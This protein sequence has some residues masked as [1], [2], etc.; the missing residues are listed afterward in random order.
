[1]H[2]YSN[3][4]DIFGRVINCLWQQT[5]GGTTTALA[6]L[7]YGYDFASNRQWRRDNVAESLSKYFDEYYGYDGVYRLTGLA[8]GQLTGTPPTGVTGQTFGEDWTL[9]PTGN[10]NEYQQLSDASTVTLDQTR[11]ASAVNEITAIDV[12]TP[13]DAPWAQPGYDAAGNMTT[14][15]QPNS[16]GNPYAATFD[17]WQRMRFLYD[18]TVPTAPVQV[19]ENQYDGRNFRVRRI[20][21]TDSGAE[22]RDFYHNDS[23]QVLQ[24][25]VAGYVDRQYVWGL[26]YIDD[27]VLRD[28]S[29]DGRSMAALRLARRQLERR[30]A[31]ATPPARCKRQRFAYTAYGVVLPLNP[32]FSDYTGSGYDWTVLYTGRIIDS[33]TG[34]ADY[35]MRLYLPSIGTFVSWDPIEYATQDGNLLRYIRNRAVSS[36]DPIGLQAATIQGPEVSI[37]TYIADF[38]SNKLVRHRP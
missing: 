12:T 2:L 36:V 8:R 1:M 6:S 21:S 15:P 26:R 4:L 20:I 31:S 25:Y 35:R 17:A 34:L 24:E 27:L 38:E 5:V 13:S 11:T 19:Q 16:P 3:G 18:T 29:S 33:R 22:T 23:W 37:V 14:M 10:W 7:G 30:R 9:D 28:W 32:D